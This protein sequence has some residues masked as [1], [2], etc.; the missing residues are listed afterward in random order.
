[1]MGS[2]KAL[3]KGDKVVAEMLAPDLL[4]LGAKIGTD[5]QQDKFKQELRN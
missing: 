2:K 5:F 1:M 4:N 3:I